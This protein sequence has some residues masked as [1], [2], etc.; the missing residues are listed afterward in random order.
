MTKPTGFSFKTNDV[1]CSKKVFY[2]KSPFKVVR[3]CSQARNTK[4]C[5]R[6]E[7]DIET[8]VDF[9][10]TSKPTSTFGKDSCST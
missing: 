8:P 10:P 4:A 1:A 7:L 9:N 6:S 3:Y 2:R 5:L